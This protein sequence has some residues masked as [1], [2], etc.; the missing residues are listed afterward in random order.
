MRITHVRVRKLVSGPGF[1][2]RAIEVEAA[3]DEGENPTAVR[4][5][6]DLWCEAQLEGK[7]VEGLRSERSELE[8]SINQL[9]RRHVALQ[10][11]GDTLKADIARLGGLQAQLKR[12]EAETG[13]ID[14]ETA[15]AAAG[16]A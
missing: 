6:L 14:I 3:V 12:V 4:Q 9:S 15:T 16:A 13:Q 1:S 8:W 11:E 2:N 10:I 7:S 5:E